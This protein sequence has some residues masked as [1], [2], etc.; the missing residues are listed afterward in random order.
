MFPAVASF[1]SSSSRLSSCTSSSSRFRPSFPWE[2]S[3][4]LLPIPNL[5]ASLFLQFSQERFPRKCQLRKQVAASS[6]FKWLNRFKSSLQTTYQNSWQAAVFLPLN[7]IIPSETIF[8]PH[9][10]HGGFTGHVSMS[11]PKRG[12]KSRCSLSSPIA[13]APHWREKWKL[14]DVQFGG[15][16]GDI[17]V[18]SGLER[19]FFLVVDLSLWKIWKSVGM[20]LPYGKTKNAPKPPTRSCWGETLLKTKKNVGH[21]IPWE[22]RL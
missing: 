20:I 10:F 13:F 4:R 15:D 22:A 7:L 18:H 17:D 3:K 6:F 16:L 19:L 14:R 21:P 2:R 9:F 1:S 11:P 12:E 5:A 8:F